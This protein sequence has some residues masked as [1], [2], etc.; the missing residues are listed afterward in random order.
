MAAMERE[1]INHQLVR[2][3]CMLSEEQ[4]VTRLP[5]LRFGDGL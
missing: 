1:I 4:A 3:G 5:R 2:S